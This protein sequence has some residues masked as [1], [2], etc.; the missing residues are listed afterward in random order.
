M[1]PEHEPDQ[2]LRVAEQTAALEQLRK[3]EGREAVKKFVAEQGYMRSPAAAQ[4]ERWAYQKGD[5]SRI[6]ARGREL[7]TAGSWGYQVPG[8]RERRERRAQRP[9]QDARKGQ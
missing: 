4:F 9:G 3:R 5:R 7:G 2:Q 1:P 6:S 8:A